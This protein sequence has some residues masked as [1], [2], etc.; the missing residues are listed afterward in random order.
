MGDRVGQ[1]LGSYRLIQLLGEGGSAEVYLGEHIYLGTMAAVKVL[2][3]V[4]AK[5]ELENFQQEARTLANLKHP[6]IVHV[7]DFGVKDKIPFLVMDYAPNGTL[8][9]RHPK[10]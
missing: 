2:H 10:G 8:R 4:L 6:N 5:D 1:D 9:Q 7:W 3:T